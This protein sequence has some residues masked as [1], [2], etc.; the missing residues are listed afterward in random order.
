MED[1]AHLEWYKEG[2]QGEERYDGSLLQVG[3]WIIFRCPDGEGFS[4]DGDPSV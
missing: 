4:L 2:E 3:E 1:F